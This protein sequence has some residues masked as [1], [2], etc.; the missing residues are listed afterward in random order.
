MAASS[1]TSAIYRGLPIAVPCSVTGGRS[2]SAGGGDV[3]EWRRGGAGGGGGRREAEKSR[4]SRVRESEL[5]GIRERGLPG[6]GGC[7][8]SGFLAV[9]SGGSA[10]GPVSSEPPA[11]AASWPRATEAEKYAIA[12]ITQAQRLIIFPF[13]A[14]PELRRGVSAPCY[15][16]C[17]SIFGPE[18]SPSF[19]EGDCSSRASPS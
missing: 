1:K 7:R 17:A 8:R 14:G 5:M 2:S 19:R 18:I 3:G 6:G 13:E 16:I 10:I 15:F 9:V 4:R 11:P 12:E